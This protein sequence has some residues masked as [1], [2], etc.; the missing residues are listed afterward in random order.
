MKKQPT[1]LGKAFEN[2]FKTIQVF[3]VIGIVGGMAFTLLGYI[4][5]IARAVWYVSSSA[6]LSVVGF[7]VG[8][9][10][11]TS[12]PGIAGS[13]ASISMPFHKD[14]TF[15]GGI[16]L[17]DFEL[18]AKISDFCGKEIHPSKCN[19]HLKER[20]VQIRTKDGLG[21]GSLLYADW[22]I[23]IILTASHVI[24]G[25]LTADDGDLILNRTGSNQYTPMVSCTSPNSFNER[26]NFK[27]AADIAIIIANNP[28]NLPYQVPKKAENKSGKFAVVEYAG[29]TPNTSY[30]WTKELAKHTIAT[31]P[32]LWTGASGS[33]LYNSEGELLG[34][35]VGSTD[36]SQL[37]LVVPVPGI[38]TE[39]LMN[40]L[41]TYDCYDHESKQMVSRK[42]LKNEVESLLSELRASQ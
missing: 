42:E 40:M 17:K 20:A 22:E 21:T 34:V 41:F 10:D 13:E 8:P 35:Y 3:F 16:S 2:L 38:T 12:L 24:E 4:L 36:K 27:E 33:S 15:T 28:G 23:S 31:V 5:G 26:G 7:I 19:D 32:S 11:A 25:N 29:E 6:Y 14:V 9:S 18:S 30:V 39:F 1:I 37:G